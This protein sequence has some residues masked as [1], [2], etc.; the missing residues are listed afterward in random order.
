MNLIKLK[1]L[2]SQLINEQYNYFNFLSNFLNN[3]SF[4]KKTGIWTGS[5]R[6]AKKDDDNNQNI[7]LFSKNKKILL[8][9]KELSPDQIIK[10]DNPIS[11]SNWSQRDIKINL[12]M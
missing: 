12:T 5:D 10:L 9:K 11:F 4:D 1:S 3:C 6:I 8:K 2:R 7:N